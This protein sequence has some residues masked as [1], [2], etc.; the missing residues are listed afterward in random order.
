MK[1]ERRHELKSN[2]LARRLEG[3]PAFLQTHAN[4][5]M[6]GLILILLVIL[7]LQYRARTAA[8]SAVQAQS[9]LAGARADIAQLRAGTYQGMPL[10]EATTQQAAQARTDLRKSAEDSLLSVLDL[11]KSDPAMQARAYLAKGD[12]YWQLAVFPDLPTTQPDLNP[13]K[14]PPELLEL[15]D[16]AYRQALKV[17][18]QDQVLLRNSARLGLA[19]VAENQSDWDKAQT[20]YQAVIDDPDAGSA[21]HDYATKRLQILTSL[22]EPVLLA[23]DLATPATEPANPPAEALPPGAFG[24]PSPF[25][26][27]LQPDDLVPTPPPATQPAPA[28]ATQPANKPG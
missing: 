23:S 7:A 26:P 9:D 11:T 28:P 19:A 22:R 13:S 6:V 14:T 4:R 20:W 2:S 17:A 25:I 3:L 5:L 10:A 18:P 8:Q 27:P 16:D 15:A 21:L 1:A 12:L 24:P